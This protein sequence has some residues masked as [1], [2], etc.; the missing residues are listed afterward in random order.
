M[1]VEARQ[2]F[3][4]P[5]MHYEVTEHRV[6]E[7]RCACGKWHR[8]EFPE[9]VKAPVQYGPREIGRASC[10]ERVFTAV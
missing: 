9:G 3:D 6:L 5:P 1:V 2:V 8:G 10:R 4:L 7:T